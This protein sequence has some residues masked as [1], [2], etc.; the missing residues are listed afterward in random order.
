M[1]ENIQET[2]PTIRRK[3]KQLAPWEKALRKY[4]PPI[5]LVMLGAIVIAMIVLLISCVIPIFV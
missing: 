1:E 4:W 5:R 3:R 2:Q